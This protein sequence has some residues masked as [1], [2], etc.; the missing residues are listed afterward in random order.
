MNKFKKHFY[1][2]NERA[3]GTPLRGGRAVEKKVIEILKDAG[4]DHL[5]IRDGYTSQQFYDWDTVIGTNHEYDIVLVPFKGEE[6]VFEITGSH[7]FVI[8]KIRDKWK[9]TDCRS[10]CSVLARGLSYSTKRMAI[11]KAEIMLRLNLSEL[12]DLSERAYQKN[13]V[14]IDKFREVDDGY[15]EFNVKTN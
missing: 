12:A 8:H 4:M 14:L 5:L 11:K 15:G 10:G 9:V 6:I 3:P 7:K 2:S 1:L 13:K